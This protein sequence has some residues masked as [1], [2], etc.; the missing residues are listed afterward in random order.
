MP[1]FYGE[2]ITNYRTG[3][4][5]PVLPG[6]REFPFFKGIFNIKGKKGIYLLNRDFL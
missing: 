1:V 3:C 6:E 5:T 4:M 2:V